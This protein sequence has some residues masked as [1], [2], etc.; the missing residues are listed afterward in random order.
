MSNKPY[1]PKPVELHA[2]GKVKMHHF[3]Y[4]VM[5]PDKPEGYSW[6][7]VYDFNGKMVVVWW[8]NYQKCL[9]DISDFERNEFGIRTKPMHSTIELKKNYRIF[10]TV[11]DNYPNLPEID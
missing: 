8:N 10:Y 3:G 1:T 2:V 11:T 6:E 7:A 9:A 5:N 4:T